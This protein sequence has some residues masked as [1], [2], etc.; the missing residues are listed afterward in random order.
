MYLNRDIYDTWTWPGEVEGVYLVRSAYYI[1]T[2]EI[3][4]ENN[5][6][7][8]KFWSIKVAPN[9][10]I[11]AWKVFLGKVPTMANLIVK[12]I[13]IESSLYPC[14]RRLTLT[15]ISRSPV[16]SWVRAFPGSKHFIPAKTKGHP[17]GCLHSD[18]QVNTETEK[19][20]ACVIILILEIA[21]LWG[22]LLPFI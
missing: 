14:S 10:H 6:L 12:G 15:T 22:F 21:S 18:A 20:Y 8:E 7:Y 5:F 2:N 4:D 11:F 16:S 17:R 19:Q 9:A 3:R 13:N 1:L